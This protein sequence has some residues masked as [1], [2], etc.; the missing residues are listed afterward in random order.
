MSM[1]CVL[2]GLALTGILTTGCAT[3]NRD[4]EKAQDKN[5]RV[6]YEEFLNRH[7]DAPQAIDAKRRLYDPEHAFLKTCA[8]A[9]KKAFE[10]FASDYSNHPLAAVARQRIAFLAETVERFSWD[11]FWKFAVRHPD[12]P[13]VVEARA[14]IPLLWIREMRCSVAVVIQVRASDPNAIQLKLKQQIRDE[15]LAEGIN[16]VF[17]SSGNNAENSG[18]PIVVVVCYNETPGIQPVPVKGDP[19]VGLAVGILFGGSTTKQ[20]CRVG[21]RKPGEQFRLLYDSIQQL[22]FPAVPVD[23]RLAIEALGGADERIMQVILRGRQ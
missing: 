14:S 12:N 13:F 20:C 5:T 1:Q 17:I 21:Y 16:P 6:G 2:A 18:L 22:K 9:S 4:W 3:I 23:K 19:L 15:L 11:G 10:G 7:P 8:I